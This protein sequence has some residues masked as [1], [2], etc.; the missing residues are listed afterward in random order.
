[1]RAMD[2]KK[3]KEAREKIDGAILAV[4][5]AWS[6]LSDLWVASEMDGRPRAAPLCDLRI[7]AKRSLNDWKDYKK[8]FR[9]ILKGGGR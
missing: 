5:D 3:E 6:V 9:E 8:R 1:M 4:T 2:K 7:D